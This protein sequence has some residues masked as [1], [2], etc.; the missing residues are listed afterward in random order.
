MY[1]HVFHVI[2]IYSFQEENETTLKIVSFVFHIFTN[3]VPESSIIL[4]HPF[5][6]NGALQI[7]LL[8]FLAAHSAENSHYVIWWLTK[9]FTEC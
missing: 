1:R 9:N 5:T 2:D 3:L 7:N 6:P 4:N 8:F